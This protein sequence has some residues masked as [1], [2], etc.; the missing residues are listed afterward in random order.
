MA[1][2]KKHAHQRV[3][4][5]RAAKAK[6]QQESSEAETSEKKS[7][8]KTPIQIQGQNTKIKAKAPSQDL[9]VLPY[10]YKD[11]PNLGTRFAALPSELRAEIFSW[12]LVRPVKWAA[13]HLP[14]CP[15]SDP[16]FDN[17][18]HRFFPNWL[19]DGELR[20]AEL[21][22]STEHWRRTAS[23]GDGLV[24]PWRSKWAPEIGN[25][26]LCSMCWDARFRSSSDPEPINMCAL[27]CLCARQ[28]REGGLE[29]LLVCKKWYEEASHV[30]Y[31]RN[32]FA[33]GNPQELSTFIEFLPPSRRNLV[34]K[35]SLLRLPPDVRVPETA[36]AELSNFRPGEWFLREMRRAYNALRTLKSLSYLEL[37]AIFLT[38]PEVVQIFR[39]PALKNLQ[40]IYFTQSRPVTA[41]EC[42]R[43][44]VWPQ[45]AF[46]QPVED[47]AFVEDVAR[48]IKG[49]R[50]GWVRG[51]RAK[52][53]PAL[54]ARER[55]RYKNR[56]AEPKKLKNKAK[57]DDGHGQDED[58]DSD[59]EEKN[60]I[61]EFDSWVI[62]GEP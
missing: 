11:G 45:R 30:L 41:A 39:G 42:P 19:R 4:K 57:S 61:D 55:I 40:D 2:R 60:L 5:Q 17:P 54:A 59:E 43:G 16:H 13:R 20:C 9:E 46:W 34:S 56:F 50:W 37:D 25:H 35:I 1:K 58:D 18:F 36:V 23:K 7:K 29:A 53:D 3:A 31:T 51:E 8:E 48:G 21:I 62:F 27:P 38:N 28:R 44:Y 15:L 24:D 12:L 10:N 22:R 49:L 26:F 33:F 47:S 14:T 32:T 52:T 6:K